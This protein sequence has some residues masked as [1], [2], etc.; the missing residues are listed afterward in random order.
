MAQLISV[1]GIEAYVYILVARYFENQDLDSLYDIFN[2]GQGLLNPHPR[3]LDKR[4]IFLALRW[5]SHAELWFRILVC[6]EL[7]VRITGVPDACYCTQISGAICEA[8]SN[9]LMLQ[10]TLMKRVRGIDLSQIL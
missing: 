9:N 8:L 7:V 2:F 1:T 5:E 4:S 3:T 6:Q 10:N